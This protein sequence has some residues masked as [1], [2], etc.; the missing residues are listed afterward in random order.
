MVPEK[1]NV[2]RIIIICAIF[3]HKGT[4]GI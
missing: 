4:S 2:C 3:Y 1:V